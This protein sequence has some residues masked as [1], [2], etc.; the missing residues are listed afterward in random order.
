MCATNYRAMAS[1]S[2]LSLAELRQGLTDEDGIADTRVMTAIAHKQGVPKGELA[3]WFDVSEETVDEWI[4]RTVDEVEQ[5]ARVGRGAG[6]DASAEPEPLDEQHDARVEYLDYEAVTDHGWAIEGDDLF[7]KAQA[8]D[9]DDDAHGTL[10]V[11]GEESIL[12]AAES[13]GLVWPY[14]CRGGAC[15]NCA[16]VCKE[17]EVHMP[18]NQVLP[19][20]AI[21]EQDVRLTCV[22]RPASTD[23]KLVVNAKHLGTLDDILLPPQQA[24]DR[25]DE[26]DESGLVDELL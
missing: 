20:D 12:D 15:A 14:S 22:G 4:D 1:L 24:P 2:D 8:A 26:G 25:G 16:A 21:R 11:G 19:D 7:E 9:L 6:G 17:G 5:S 18:V 23:L 10:W 3:D 13:E